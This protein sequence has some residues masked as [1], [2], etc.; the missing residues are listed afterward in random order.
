MFYRYEIKSNGKEDVLY[1]YLTMTYEFSKELE[2][3]TE[4]STINEKAKNFINNNSIDFHGDK[5]CLVVDG[6]IIKTLNIAKEYQVS[7]VNK[8]NNLSNQDFIVEVKYNEKRKERMTLEYYLLGVL[9]TN[10]LLNIELTTLK[11]LCLLYRTYAYN[12]MEKY[13]FIN[14]SNEF[15][16][17]RPISYYKVLWLDNY[18]FYYNRIEKAIKDTDGEFLTYNDQYIYPFIHLCSNGK[19][20]QNKDYKYLESVNSLWDLASPNYLEIKDFDYTELEKKFQISKEDF[21]DISVTEIDNDSIIK[22]IKIK[23]K[24][25]SGTDFKNI[26]NLKSNDI[27]IIVNPTFVRFITRGSGNNLGLSLFGANEIA[28]CGCS[29]QS[30]IKYYYPNITIKK[31][32]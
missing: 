24:K 11:A 22:Q 18:Q 1:L 16:L 29:Y 9:A 15:Q 21:M 26:L 17:Y 30:I 7:E 25:F 2:G 20:S 32:K 23:N 4:S 31:N 6:I 3:D 19:T 8:T 27:V 13:G 28:K 5:I 12:M 14:A 10:S